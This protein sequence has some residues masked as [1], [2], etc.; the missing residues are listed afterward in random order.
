MDLSSE[1][2]PFSFTSTPT[3]DRGKAPF[4]MEGLSNFV[5]HKRQRKSAVLRVGRRVFHGRVVKFCLFHFNPHKRQRKSAVLR[6]GR[7]VFHGRVVK[8]CLFHFNPHKRQRK[9][10][11]LRVG[12]RVFHGRVVKFCLFHFNPHKRQRKSAVLRVGPRFFSGRIVKSKP[13]QATNPR[14][15]CRDSLLVS[16]QLHLDLQRG[17]R[18][19]ER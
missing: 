15:G 8:F 9:S 6:V 4:S 1:P 19:Q 2:I 17:V 18:R 3:K 14:S 16:S 5:P 13:W 10:A 12:R 7:R 11:V